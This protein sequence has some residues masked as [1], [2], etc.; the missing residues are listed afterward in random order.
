MTDCHEISELLAAHVNDELAPTEREAVDGHLRTCTTCR[1][2]HSSQA[3]VRQRLETLSDAL[4]GADIK[5]VT[6]SKIRAAALRRWY[7]RPML[8][9]AL[10]AAVIVVALAV[11]L[12]LQFFG[13]GVDSRIAEAY[14]AVRDLQTYRIS[15]TTSTDA[16]GETGSIE[17]EWSF[18]APDQYRGSISGPAM[19]N[20]FI[21]IGAEQYV[22]SSVVDGSFQSVVLTGDLL[23][24][25]PSRTGT[26]KLLASMS[27]LSEL[28]DEVV[29]GVDAR[30]V[31]GKIDFGK[32]L[33][34]QLVGLDPA[35]P[36]YSQAIQWIDL[37]RSTRI[38]VDVWIAKDNGLLRQMRLDVSTPTIRSGPAGIQQ[39][40]AIGYVTD[41]RYF[42][43]DAVIDITR[44][45]DAS[46]ELESGWVAMGN[47][48]SAP[49]VTPSLGP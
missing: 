32:Y 40:G 46:G 28:P 34:E 22:H 47:G 43:F 29:D 18:V 8:R 42:D 4:E 12:T 44:P 6:M 33:E 48:S 30:H 26:L 19:N 23:S 2:S 38:E 15:G 14:A 39:V 36:E 16:D 24:P 20:E 13:A 21:V 17:F 7:A 11:P 31:N 1:I 41:V 35:S 45:V 49:A 25:V 9:A 3:W 27:D 37:Q 5:A 10:L